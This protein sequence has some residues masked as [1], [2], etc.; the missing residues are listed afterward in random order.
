MVGSWMMHTIESDADIREGLAAL[1]EADE[2]LVPV[3]AEAGPVPLRRRAGGFAGLAR[4]VTA[5]QLSNRAAASIW[6]RLEDR[7][8]TVTPARLLAAG[9]DQLRGC[10]LSAAKIAT[11]EGAAREI[12]AGRL[13]PEILARIDAEAAHG[14][15]CKLR[16]IGPWTAD[17]YLLF[18]LGHADIFPSGDLALR[19]AVGEALGLAARPGAA[20]VAELAAIWAP[21]RGV[22]A[23]LFWAWH[24]VR[25]DR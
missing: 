24:A 1:A 13:D 7:L 22:A 10:G 11:L 20:E 4:I 17:I 15:L 19:V 9:H 3:I 5:Q 12:E 21:W 16:G 2:R 25:R 23:R 14:A 8:G 6:G 18:C